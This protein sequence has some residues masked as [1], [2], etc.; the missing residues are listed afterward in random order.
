M[1]FV[2][3][4]GCSPLRLVVVMDS[5]DAVR[6]GLTEEVVA[7]AV[8]SR[9]RAARLYTDTDNREVPSLV[10]HVSVVNSQRRPGGAFVVDV[11]LS[12]HL[13][14]PLSGLSFPAQTNDLT[15]LLYS[16][17]GLHS[18]NAAFILSGIAQAMDGFLDAYLRVNEPACY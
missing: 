6:M 14:D 12:K 10:I 17:F 16:K 2:Y 15:G 13:Y 1:R 4:T 3:W 7:T 9:L 8:R 5:E 11:A 18:G